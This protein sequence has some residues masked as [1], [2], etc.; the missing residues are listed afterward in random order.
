VITVSLLIDTYWAGSEEHGL[1]QLRQLRPDLFPKLLPNGQ[2]NYRRRLLGPVMEQIRRLLSARWQLIDP[3]DALRITDSAPVVVCTYKRARSNANFSGPEYFGKALS[4]AARIFGFRLHASISDNQMVGQWLLA[5]AAHH[6]SQLVWPLFCDESDLTILG[7][8]AYIS[9]VENAR[10]K[11]KRN[12][13]VIAPPR[14]D[15]RRAK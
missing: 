9:P 8:G 15:A 6:D 7:D 14:K 3:D 1:A 5:P 11:T 12:N 13:K 2:F 4:K 10:L